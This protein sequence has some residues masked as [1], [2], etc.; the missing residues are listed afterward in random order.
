MSDTVTSNEVIRLRPLSPHD[1]EA[2]Q[3]G[4]DRAIVDSL[5][6][7]QPPNAAQV[8]HWLAE[9]EAAWATGGPVV[10]LGVEDCAT[11]TLCG[12]VGIQRGLGY[13]EPGQVNITYS[14]YPAWRRRGYTTRAVRLAMEV[15]R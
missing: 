7:G 6:G 10:D 11:G 13:L 5:G 12:T 4:C 15:A 8:R 14:L 3:A 9:A 1:A 2:H